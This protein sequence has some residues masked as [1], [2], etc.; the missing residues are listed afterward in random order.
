MS[1]P[2]AVVHVVLLVAVDAGV[3][4]VLNLSESVEQLATEAL[5]DALDLSVLVANHHVAHQELSS[6]SPIRSG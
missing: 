4:L 5:L 6:F 2:R 3:Q 1:A